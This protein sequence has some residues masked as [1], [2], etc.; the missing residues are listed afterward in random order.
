M[1]LSTRAI[2]NTEVV[3]PTLS[4]AVQNVVVILI[5]LIIAIG[6]SSFRK[7]PNVQMMRDSRDICHS[8]LEEDSRREQ[9]Q[10]WDV[11]F[12]QLN[13]AMRSPSLYYDGLD[14]LIASGSWQQIEMCALGW[15]HLQWF[16]YARILHF[17]S[18]GSGILLLNIFA[19]VMALEHCNAR[20]HSCRIPVW[21]SEIVLVCCSPMIVFFAIIGISCKPKIPEAHTH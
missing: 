13:H 18:H 12:L 16:R 15:Q 17:S 8:S 2:S 14:L 21:H 9:C 20:L 6:M 5:G 19:K 7:E 3:Q 11:K 1:S 4:R 10:D